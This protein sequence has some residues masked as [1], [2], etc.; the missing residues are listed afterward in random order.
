MTPLRLAL[1]AV[2]AAALIN[3]IEGVPQAAADGCS[4]S[5]SGASSYLSIGMTCGQRP[6]RRP[7]ILS[8]LNRSGQGSPPTSSGASTSGGTSGA[9]G[10]G[11]FGKAGTGS[12]ATGLHLLPFLL[13]PFT[14]NGQTLCTGGRAAIPCSPG[15]LTATTPQAGAAAG[16]AAR[17]QVTPGLVLTELERI[18]LPSLR[19][20]TQPRDKT[21][22]NFATI[23]YTTPHTVART[24]T[25]LGQ[26]VQVEARA[27]SFT[28]HYGDGD[29]EVT[30]EPGAAYPAKDITHKYL[31]AHVTVRPSVDVGYTG[32]FR[33][34]DGPWQVI[35]GT[36]TIAGPVTP[37]RVSE[38][39]PVLSGDY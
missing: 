24:V 20:R 9:S 22:V 17:P 13:D 32:R 29:V 28:W 36:V 1:A 27:V 8:R 31:H 35:P 25:L 11:S 23:F 3:C 33:V 7:P 39:T 12:G 34:G 18:G 6:A 14:S 26:A 16:R 4:A 38:A 2:L 21:L 30:E 10:S 19:A 37:L 5:G 15:T